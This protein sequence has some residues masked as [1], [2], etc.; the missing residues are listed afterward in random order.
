MKLLCRLALC[1]A[2]GSIAATALALDYPPRKPGL[3][4][5]RIGDAGVKTPPMVTQQCIDAATATSCCATWG[6]A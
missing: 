3:W 2:A 1:I 6:R 4:E 5:M